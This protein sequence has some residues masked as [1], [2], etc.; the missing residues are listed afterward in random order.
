MFHMMPTNEIRRARAF[1][2]SK[3]SLDA[4]YLAISFSETAKK[5]ILASPMQ[6]TEHTVDGRNPARVDRWFIHVY[7]IIIHYSYLSIGFTVSCAL[8]QG[9]ASNFR[10]STP[11]SSPWAAD[12]NRNTTWNIF[13]HKMEMVQATTIVFLGFY[14]PLSFLGLL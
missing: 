5:T 7:P 4:L 12:A 10:I 2:I 13:P 6:S 8:L 1:V 9:R 14:Q 11:S 3:E